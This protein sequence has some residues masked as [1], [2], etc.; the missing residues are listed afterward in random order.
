M[1]PPLGELGRWDLLIRTDSHNH[2]SDSAKRPFKFHQ[3]ISVFDLGHWAHAHL[4]IATFFGPISGPVV[5]AYD[6]RG[7]H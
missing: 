2:N 5:V 7:V 3:S 4:E 6:S 1:V